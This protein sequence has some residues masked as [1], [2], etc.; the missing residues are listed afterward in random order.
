MDSFHVPSDDELNL[1]LAKLKLTVQKD[2]LLSSANFSDSFLKRT[3][4]AKHCNA[5]KSKK[6]LKS[7]AEWHQKHLGSASARLS[8]AQVI[9]HT[10]KVQRGVSLREKLS[11]Q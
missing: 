3:L 9:A 2:A 11:I 7:Y 5:L 4:W 8:I 1:A 6:L 10:S